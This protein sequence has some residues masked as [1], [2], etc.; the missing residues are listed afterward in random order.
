[1][2]ILENLNPPQ[3]RSVEKIEGPLLILA[4]PGSGKTKVITHR[5]AYLH[6]VCQV[7]PRN[8]MAVTF[9]NKAAREMRERLHILLGPPVQQLSV[10]TFHAIC[11]RILRHDGEAIGIDS[12][13]VIYD[14][15]DQ[16]SII[17]ASLQDLRLDTKKYVPRA[18]LSAI[19]NAKSQLITSEEYIPTSYFGEVVGRVYTN[20]HRL[21][22]QNKAQDFDDLIMN[23]V[24]LFRGQPQVLEKYQN[25]YV[26]LLVDEFQDTNLAQ[27]T[28][29]RQLS[30]KHCNICVVGDPDQ[31]IYSWRNADPRN[32]LSF[33]KD[34]PD[35][36]VILLEQNYRSS[37]TILAAAQHLISANK[38]RRDKGLWTENE[39]GTPI[40]VAEAHSEG[41]EAQLVAFHLQRLVSHD[42]ITLRDCAVTY[43]TNAQSR[44]VEEAFLR[45]GI[46][47]QLVGGTRFYA[48]KEIKD[49]IAY[50]RIIQNP[51]DSVSL[52]R[53]INTPPRGIGQRTVDDLSRWTGSQGMSL[54]QG[55]E[56]IATDRSNIPLTTRA[57]QT[58]MNFFDMLQNML[59]ARDDLKSDE[60]VKLVFDR[61]KYK[62]YLQDMEDGQERWDNIMELYVVAKEHQHLQPRDSLTA[63][64]ERVALISELDGMVGGEDRVTLITLHQVKGLEFP[65]VFMLGMEEGVLPH[66]KSFD[67]P[68]AMEEE[69]RLCYV[70]MTRA[71]KHLYMCRA[72]RRSLAGGTNANPPSRFLQDIPVHLVKSITVFQ[73]TETTISNATAVP[74]TEALSVGDCVHHAAFGGGIV[75]S[76]TP[77]NDDYEVV[78]GFDSAGEK[79]LLLS[80]APLTR[81]DSAQL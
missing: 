78:I 60:I 53:V 62:E 20:Y 29:A 72:Y 10:G 36:T 31:S 69:R 33:E 1:M 49:I 4:G 66:F 75:L 9:T 46:P 71:E 63:F 81:M 21:L 30:N 32:I 74:T 51:H 5:I 61:T 14:E 68:S 55:L 17:K 52:A 73:D 19:S 35:A 76:C 67:D 59:N 42:G 47:Y 39:L 18:I 26:H 48:R 64:L 38:E 11:S 2:N 54:Y 13:F 23:T 65:V 34:Y 12:Q 70:G 50:L 80:L 79:K 7:S 77:T 8:I 16:L 40:V 56:M 58:L 28:I 24:L 25:R 37:Q 41:E 22:R 27:Y 57:M 43:R 3:R 44:P 6:K 15:D 45:H